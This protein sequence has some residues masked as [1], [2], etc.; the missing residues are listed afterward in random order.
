MQ[1]RL[2]ARGASHALPGGGTTR[3]PVPP[4]PDEA[5]PSGRPVGLLYSACC[6]A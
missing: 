1:G 5:T 2:H 4:P 6:A 3:F